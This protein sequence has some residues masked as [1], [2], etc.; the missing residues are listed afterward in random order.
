MERGMQ[1]GETIATYDLALALRGESGK[2]HVT[3]PT[4]EIYQVTCK[5]GHSITNLQ[6][7]G[8]GS[9]P[10]PFVIRKVAEPVSSAPATIAPVMTAPNPTETPAQPRS[11]KAPFLISSD[12]DD[13]LSEKSPA[14]VI[15]SQVPELV[16]VSKEIHDLDLVYLDALQSTLPPTAGVSLRSESP[17]DRLNLTNACTTFNQFD[18]EIRRLHAQLDEI[19]YRARK[20]FFQA[21]GMA[22]GA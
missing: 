14:A 19:R 10:Q 18:A 15:V 13:L 2:F 16:P 5:S 1:L 17:Q 6:W 22:A 20:K 4:G 7:S 9:N 21:K 11:A 12:E 8:D 3:S